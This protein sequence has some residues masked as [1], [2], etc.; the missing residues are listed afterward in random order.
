MARIEHTIRQCVIANV[1]PR[2]VKVNEEENN[3]SCRLV[4]LVVF[5]CKHRLLHGYGPRD[6]NDKHADCTSQ[7]HGSAFEPWRYEGNGGSVDEAPR[8]VAE[9]DHCLSILDS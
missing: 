3:N 1:V 8:R 7:E 6:V 2:R 5:Q 9:I 4:R